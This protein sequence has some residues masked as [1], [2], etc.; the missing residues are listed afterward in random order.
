MLEIERLKLTKKEKFFLVILVIIVFIINFSLVFNNNVWC[1]EAATINLTNLSFSDMF[2]SIVKDVHPPL[3][4]FVLKIGTHFWGKS[5][6]IY[7]LISIIP[8]MLLIIIGDIWIINNLNKNAFF[9]SMLF[10]MLVGLSPCSQ[11]KNVEVRMYT[12]AALWVCLTAILCWEVNKELNGTRGKLSLVCCALLAMYTHYFALLAVGIILCV[13]FMYLFRKKNRLCIKIIPTY[14][15]IILGY[16]PWLPYMFKQARE[17]VGIW[18]IKIDM[19][20]AYVIDLFRY[21]FEGD[22]SAFFSNEFTVLSWTIIASVILV[23]IYKICECEK[24]EYKEIIYFGL[25]LTFCFFGTV[26]IGTILSYIFHPI[27]FRRYLFP[28]LSCMW[29]GIAVLFSG[30]EI[31]KRDICFLV[32][33]FTI[34]GISAYNSSYNREYVTGTNAFLSFA[35]DNIEQDAIIVNDFETCMC[36]ELKYYFPQNQIYYWEDQVLKS[37]DGVTLWTQ[38]VDFDIYSVENDIWY[39]CKGGFELDFDLLTEKG[40]CVDVSYTGNID[41]YYSFTLYH[42]RK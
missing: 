18:P 38:E 28:S 7:K 42:I 13:E 24:E 35:H 15:L 19:S 26:I 20:P 11:G 32:S 40:Y 6:A 4:Y 21:P 25:A 31:K 16:L 10:T 5:L 41:N 22:Y 34:M 3:Y 30:L 39:F 29:L 33:F 8:V 9:S 36:W 1:D 14:G 23:S 2:D 27:I 12:W 17:N 37:N